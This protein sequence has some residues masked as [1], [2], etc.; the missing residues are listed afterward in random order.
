VL[1]P[2]FAV[3][4]YQRSHRLSQLV[5]SLS[6]GSR[7]LEVMTGLLEGPMKTWD[8]VKAEEVGELGDLNFPKYEVL[9]DSRILDL[10]N[11]NPKAAGKTEATSLVYGYRRVKAVKRQANTGNYTLSL[12]LLATHPQT[13]V[14]FPEQELQPTLRSSPMESKA[15]GE[16]R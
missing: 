15:P 8:G 14:R 7:D 3:K 1:L 4:F 9:Q 11:W 13:Q 5:E 12:D 10:R 6:Q 2:Y 16:K